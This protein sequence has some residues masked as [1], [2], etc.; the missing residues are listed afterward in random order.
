VSTLREKETHGVALI[1]LLQ[2]DYGNHANV[3]PEQVISLLSS[4]HFTADKFPTAN[5]RKFP[6]YT[7]LYLPAPFLVTS[8]L[9][10][11]KAGCS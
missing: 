2:F 4:F 10:S 8:S 9:T 3:D 1:T 7:T 5:A 6:S 11:L